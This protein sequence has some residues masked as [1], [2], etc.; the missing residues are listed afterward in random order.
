MRRIQIAR[1]P[2]NPRPCQLT[3]PIPTIPGPVIVTIVIIGGFQK[4]MAQTSAAYNGTI[5]PDLR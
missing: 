5:W 4:I 1:S 2:H 3:N